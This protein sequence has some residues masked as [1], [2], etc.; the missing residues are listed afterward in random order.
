V[1]LAVDASDKAVITFLFAAITLLIVV[2]D[3]AV[4]V[5][6]LAVILPF[7]VRPDASTE[8]VGVNLPLLIAPTSHLLSVKF[9]PKP[10]PVP[11]PSLCKTLAL[12]LSAL[13]SNYATPY[14][15]YTTQYP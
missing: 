13:I 4:N 3:E 1:P 6:V 9:H 11:V 8:R 15:S 14:G 5:S 2:V 12:I 10:V 7:T